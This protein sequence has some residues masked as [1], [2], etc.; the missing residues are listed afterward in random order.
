MHQRHAGTSSMGMKHGHA[1]CKCSMDTQHAHA[2]W[3]RCMQM[4]HGQCSL[5]MQ[6][7]HEAQ[8]SKL[9]YSTDMQH[10]KSAGTCSMVMHSPY[11][12]PLLSTMPSGF[13]LWN[14]VSSVVRQKERKM[15]EFALIS[16]FFARF[17]SRC[18]ASFLASRARA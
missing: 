3:T 17:S 5:D 1:A 12:R 4:Q 11:S 9:T 16:F 13:R 7:G 8:N 2:A 18:S 15:H 10:E 6:C 14:L